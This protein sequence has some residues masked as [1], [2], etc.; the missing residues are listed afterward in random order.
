MA[1]SF[2]VPAA[3]ILLLAALLGGCTRKPKPSTVVV[4]VLRDLRS[5]YGSEL[6]RR[7]L[8]FQGSNPRL[9]SGQAVV[10]QSET[11]E[12][13]EML[14]KQ[15]SDNEGIDVII[16]NSPDDAQVSAA[17]QTALP[18]APNICAGLK[19]CPA[20]VPAI[21]PQQVSGTERQAAQM[22]VDFLQKAP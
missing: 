12:Y 5:I 17:L 22:F 1:L 7:I 11:G 9:E 6:D 13:K 3:A 4:H 2:R 15:G 19:A 20:N 8:D 14:A 10:I 18:Q 21:I 16:L